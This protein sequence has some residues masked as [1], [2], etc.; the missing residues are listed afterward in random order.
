MNGASLVRYAVLV[1]L[2]GALTTS[3][4]MAAPSHIAIGG[5]LSPGTTE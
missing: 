2:V 4:G 1:G 3:V 5:V